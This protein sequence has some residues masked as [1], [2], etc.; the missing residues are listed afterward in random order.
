MKERIRRTAARWPRRSTRSSSGYLARAEEDGVGRL[1]FLAR[2]A[3]PYWKSAK[4]YCD[5]Y[6]LKIDCRYLFASRYTLRVPL[7]AEDMGNA[8]ELIFQRGLKVTLRMLLSRSGL[9]GEAAAGFVR[10]HAEE[11]AALVFREGAESGEDDAPLL[12]APLGAAAL[13]RLKGFFSRCGDYLELVRLASLKKREAA[14]G[15]LAQEGVLD[16]VRIGIV[17]SGWSGSL[18]TSIDAL[19]RIG[20][21]ALPAEGYYFGLYSHPGGIDE[22]R[23]HAF[24][25]APAKRLGTS[26]RPTEGACRALNP[27]CGRYGGKARLRSFPSNKTSSMNDAEGKSG[28]CSTARIC[29]LIRKMNFNSCL[30]EAVCAAPGGTARGYRL[31]GGRWLPELTGSRAA[32]SALAKKKR[33]FKELEAKTKNR[34]AAHASWKGC[35]RMSRSE[36]R[37]VERGLS[38][39]MAHPTRAAAEYY[40]SLEFSDDMLDA[41]AASL[42]PAFTKDGFKSLYLAGKLRKLR[43]EK[44]RPPISAWPEG[45]IVRGGKGRL[46]LAEYHAYKLRGEI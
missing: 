27:R 33:F 31:S 32:K 38:R 5:A 10:R 6:G 42:A 45:S 4:A 21:A 25:F 43:G 2:D 40:G 20:G 12:D 16:D 35:R 37:S 3:Y 30:F 11:L 24:W 17:D 34:I 22:S 19:R 18:Q 44:P 13:A 9:E 8:L 39:L 36:I 26:D 14:M 23:R 7:Y 15:Y 1:Y 29:S 28:I 46:K 41:E